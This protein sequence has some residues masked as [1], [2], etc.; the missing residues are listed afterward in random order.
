M[1]IETFKSAFVA[2]LVT[3][4]LFG[5]IGGISI[6]SIFVYPAWRKSARI[7]RKETMI[8][9]EINGKLGQDLWEYEQLITKYR[10]EKTVAIDLLAP[11]MFEI[12]SL[13]NKLR[14][15]GREA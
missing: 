9:K 10:A 6:S 15:L 7:W 13:K 4:L 1:D 2:I 12:E 14:E 8:Q 5:M 11:A 3:T